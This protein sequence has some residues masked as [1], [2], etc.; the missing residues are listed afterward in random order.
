M[1]KAHRTWQYKKYLLLLISMVLLVIIFGATRAYTYYVK[2]SNKSVVE[3]TPETKTNGSPKPK[4]TSSTSPVNNADELDGSGIFGTVKRMVLCTDNINSSC[5][6]EPLQTDLVIYRAAATGC[7]NCPPPEP[8]A[9]FRTDSN[10]HFRQKLEPGD[11]TI[12]TSSSESGTSSVSNFF[13]IHA[14]RYTELNITVNQ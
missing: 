9:R 8:V 14:S 11:Y 12:H 13:Q 3:Q 10:G 6:T 1:K 5:T 7:Y 2:Q 4:P